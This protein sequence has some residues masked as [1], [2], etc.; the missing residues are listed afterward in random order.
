MDL[1]KYNNLPNGVD[2]I[3]DRDII[4]YNKYEYRA[5]VNLAGIRRT[6]YCDTHQD[7]DQRIVD[8]TNQNLNN[9][10]ND[11]VYAKRMREEVKSYDVPALYRWIDWKVTTDKSVM[12][13]M[14]GDKAAVFSNDLAFLHTLDQVAPGNVTYTQARTGVRIAGIKYFARKPKYSHRIYL[15]TR[16]AKDDAK[17]LI[18]DF[19][20]FYKPKKGK[21]PVIQA[22]SSL[23]AML[24]ETRH[25]KSYWYHGW[26]QSHH[27]IDYD[28]EKM[29]TLMILK[30]GEF[31]GKGF[32]LE[33]REL[34]T[35]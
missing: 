18:S 11:N 29:L 21:P 7:L 15:K 20:K 19:L 10:Y 17:K 33:K 26:F 2:K 25:S 5:T 9:W 6:Y 24:D 8:M 27:Y 30:F 13:R 34:P 14:E 31:L 4:F 16:E 32:K 23:T 1:S 22:S 3:E 12:I 28:D 35:E